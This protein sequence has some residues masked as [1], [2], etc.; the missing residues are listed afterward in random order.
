MRGCLY[1]KERIGTNCA[2]Y[3]DRV[4]LSLDGNRIGLEIAIEIYPEYIYNNNI[5]LDNY[6]FK[7]RENS[8]V[9]FKK[10]P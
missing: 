2:S 8:I 6:I 9:K 3:T 4:L 7:M 10:S 5:K 1:G